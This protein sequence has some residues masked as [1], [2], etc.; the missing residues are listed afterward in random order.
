MALQNLTILYVEDNQETQRLVA[1]L[2]TT[3]VKEVYLASDGQEG[4]EV[5]K[6]K[7]P[8]IVLTDINMPNMNGLEMS[9]EIRNLN[10]AQTIAVFTAFNDPDYMQEASRLGIGTYLLK[11]FER[12]QFFNSLNYLAMVIEMQQENPSQNNQ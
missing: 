3:M 4:L 1:R 9:S 11:P 5:Y 12:E 7:T 2:L 6:D 8:D 10:Q